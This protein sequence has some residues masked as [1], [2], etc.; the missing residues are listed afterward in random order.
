MKSA[1]DS[2]PRSS[3]ES[4]GAL[5]RRAGLIV[6]IAILLLLTACGWLLFAPVPQEGQPATG[7]PPSRVRASGGIEVRDAT[8]F[9]L[10]SS[11]PTRSGAYAR[12]L[13]T[14]ERLGGPIGFDRGFIELQ[15]D[16]VGLPPLERAAVPD[17][18]DNVPARL[19]P[20][21]PA[22]VAVT[23][24]VPRGSMDATLVVRTSLSDEAS[25]VRVPLRIETGAGR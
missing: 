5:H 22:Q 13:F 18:V 6:A 10:D 12:V 21:K 16:Q 17:G 19:E 8:V 20:R 23:F 3:E 7:G 24:G 25:A 4:R 9:V 14:L 11:A 15:L 2:N 1:E